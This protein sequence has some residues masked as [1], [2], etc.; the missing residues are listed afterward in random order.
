MK[1][2]DVRSTARRFG[3]W[4]SRVG[5]RQQKDDFVRTVCALRMD[6]N[7][8]EGNAAP[9]RGFVSVHVILLSVY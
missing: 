2:N 5:L 1:R 6:R 7:K 3:G 4:A 8:V 9:K